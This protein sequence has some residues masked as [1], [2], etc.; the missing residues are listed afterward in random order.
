[1]LFC[2]RR[3]STRFPIPAGIDHKRE[4]LAP[5]WSGDQRSGDEGIPWE[6]TEEQVR[7]K[8]HWVLA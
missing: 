2:K 3:K 6:Q 4:N 8:D 1:M 5:S 7:K